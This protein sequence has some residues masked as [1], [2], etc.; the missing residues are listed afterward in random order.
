VVRIICRDGKVDRPRQ[1][2]TEV[3]RALTPYQQ[4]VKE[5]A[6]APKRHPGRW[7]RF[8][9]DRGQAGAQQPA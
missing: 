5:A 2:P 8:L 4:A 3:V 7:P 6:E 1:D 9:R